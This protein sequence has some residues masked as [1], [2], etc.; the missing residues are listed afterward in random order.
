MLLLIL[1]SVIICLCCLCRKRRRKNKKDL[2]AARVPDEKPIKL[3]S[4]QSSETGDK[5]KPGLVVVETPRSASDEPAK[6][7]VKSERFIDL[8]DAV[9][10]PPRD[11][12]KEIFPPANALSAKNLVSAKEDLR[13]KQVADVTKKSRHEGQKVRN[14]S[15][16][17]HA[18]AGIGKNKKSKKSKF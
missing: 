15:D 7:F 6:Y 3:D 12:L 8:N 17:P 13:P 1:L 5:D 11:G 2:E 10:S 16:Q 14:A 4:T 18:S 9:K